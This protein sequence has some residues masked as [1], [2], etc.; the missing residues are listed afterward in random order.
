MALAIH[1][2]RASTGPPLLGGT[3]RGSRQRHLFKCGPC[4]KRLLEIEY[5]LALEE[6]LLGGGSPIPD[7]R[8]PLFIVHDTGDG[9][10]YSRA[11]KTGGKWFAR[12]WGKQLQG[13][14]ECKTMREAN[15]FLIQS[16]AEMFP[17]HR[18]TR[19]CCL[20][21]ATTPRP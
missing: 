20:N 11:E 18:C 6:A 9:F 10:I 5:K 17:E 7:K 19:R 2:A 21:P 4:L 8:K 16:F 12:H 13:G 1:R 14:R 3:L 15:E